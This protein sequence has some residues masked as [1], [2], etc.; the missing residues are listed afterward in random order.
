MESGLPE[1]ERG[2]TDMRR[3]RERKTLEET[4]LYKFFKDY[5]KSDPVSNGS[6]V[7]WT[8]GKRGKFY[9][10]LDR[11]KYTFLINYGPSFRLNC[12]GDIDTVAGISEINEGGVGISC[13]TRQGYI[14]F[15]IPR[16]YT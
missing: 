9:V 12:F 14:S 13:L 3:I 10:E 6:T 8:A 16:Y 5:F 15:N 2:S 7:Y 4:Y 11:E 1:K